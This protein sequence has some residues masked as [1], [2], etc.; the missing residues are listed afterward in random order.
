[1][2]TPLVPTSSNKRR[3]R[4]EIQGLRAL[5]ALQIIVFHAWQ[6][7]SPIGVDVFIMV[8]AFLLADS[9]IR[10]SDA[11]KSYSVCKRWIQTFRRLLPPLVVTIL[12]AIALTIKYLPKTRWM[13]IINQSWPSLFY[14]QN[15]YLQSELVDYFAADHS[16]S[17]PLMHMWCIAVQGQIFLIFPVVFAV[18]ALLCR[19]LNI[20]VRKGIFT[21]FS[22]LALTSFAWL[23]V[24]FFD[25]TAS[26]YYFDT[27]IRFWEFAI[28]VLAA[29]TMNRVKAGSKWHDALGWFSIAIIVVFGLLS[30]GTYP[31]PIC[32]LPIVA[33][34]LVM[35]FVRSDSNS[36]SARLLSCRPLVYIGDN[37]YALYLVHWPIFAVY[38]GA[39]QQA[40]LS[41][42]EGGFLFLVSLGL[43]VLL[44]ELVDNPVRSLKLFNKTW[45]HKVSVIVLALAVGAG[46]IATASWQ[47][48]KRISPAKHVTVSSHPGARILLQKNP[49]TSFKEDPL[50]APGELG[51][52]WA[53]LP[54]QCDG[55]FAGAPDF[56]E[57]AGHN[58][59]C[60]QLH[61]EGTDG[62]NVLVFG[63][64]HAEQYLPAI[65]KTAENRNWNLAALLMGGC[66]ISRDFDGHD[67][68]CKK[69][70]QAGLDWALNKAQP[71]AVIMVSTLTQP[72]SPD[73]VL[74]GHPHVVSEFLTKGIK[75]IGMRDTPNYSQNIYEC[76]VSVPNPQ[77][78]GVPYGQVYS[79][80][81]NGLPVENPGFHFVDLSPQ[82]CPNDAC[83]PLV[84]NLYVYMDH[85]HLTKYYSQS[86]EDFFTQQTKGILEP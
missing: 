16:L 67:D 64:S 15:W 76:A 23:L 48:N 47:I 50:P 78:C 32:I 56:G 8:S 49:P 44:T 55:S 60:R 20:S 82:I 65:Q 86:L 19:K 10:G 2:S 13:E 37:S 66:K 31:G 18:T 39:R 77:S 17:S 36:S 84:G 61:Q 27:R 4:P 45:L 38:M 12:L 68:T 5:C 9:F 59:S 52:Q 40:N 1:M 33:A 70:V 79:K 58:N 29:L 72:G 83:S 71:D 43:A 3:F 81:L 80:T 73:Q 11:G 62:A 51:K 63:D 75:V 57:A 34:C 26:Q 30:V 24:K 74:P 28:G 7:G 53:S 22:L 41:L 6:V 25:G 21:V 35:L 85:D 14:Y 42:F 69:W 54:Y 46:G